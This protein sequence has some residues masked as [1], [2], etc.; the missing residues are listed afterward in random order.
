MQQRIQRQLKSA[1]SHLDEAIQMAQSGAYCIDV[2]HE[3]QDVLK[4]LKAADRLILEKHM[5][6]CVRQ[7][8]D[9]K[10]Q[11]QAFTEILAAFRKKL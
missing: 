1:Q 11:E 10:K 6:T 5:K 2:I 8:I 9:Q 4:F 7:L 3:T